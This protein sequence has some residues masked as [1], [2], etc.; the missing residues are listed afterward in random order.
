MNQ[1]SMEASNVDG[2][3]LAILEMESPA[4]QFADILAA[5]IWNALRQIPA[6]V[7]L[8]ILDTTVRLQYADLTVKIMGNARNPMSVIV[9]LDMEDQSVMKFIVNQHANMEEY[10]WFETSAPVHMV[11][12]DH[13][14]KQ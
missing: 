13:D 1:L 5:G 14:V 3:L 7:S 2:A 11:L 12:L 9:C 10:V 8:V 6:A 4:K